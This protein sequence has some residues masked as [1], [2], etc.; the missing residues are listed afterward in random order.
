MV[1][2]VDSARPRIS[3]RFRIIDVVGLPRADLVAL[4]EREATSV[5]L[6]P[7][8]R[9]RRPNEKDT[10]GPRTGASESFLSWS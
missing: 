6:P 3:A 7:P 9:R 5:S 1:R 4:P 8:G 2:A 10:D